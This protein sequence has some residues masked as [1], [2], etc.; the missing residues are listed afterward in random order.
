M[1]EFEE[2]EQKLETTEPTEYPEAWDSKTFGNKI[3]GTVKRIVF[4]IPTSGF[5][6]SGNLLELE[7]PDGTMRSVWLPIVLKK[8]IER[9]NIKEGDK[10]GIKALGKPK[11]KR[12]Y[13]FKV[14]KI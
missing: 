5:T 1:S 7:Q 4:D 8:T 12:Y 10:I 13:D 3:T 6:G 9:M 14:V 2:I 11:G